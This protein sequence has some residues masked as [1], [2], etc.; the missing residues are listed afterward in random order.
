M[1][2]SVQALK[3]SPLFCDLPEKTIQEEILPHGM[4]L[5][6]P[7]GK[8]II[9]YLE[10]IDFFGIVISG[11]I[12]IMHIYA[13]GNFTIVDM[14]EKGD[15]IGLDLACT[16]SRISS[17]YAVSETPS[18]ILCFPASLISRSGQLSHDTYLIIISKLLSYLSS[19]NMRKEYRL[20]ILFQKGV[21]DRI[22][23][24]L[25]MQANKYQS[26]TF[27][28]PFSRNELASYLCIN[29]T[30][31]SHELSLLA[32]EGIIEFNRNTFTLKEWNPAAAN[33]QQSSSLY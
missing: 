20:A 17:Y 10:P 4:L 33:I 26:N 27:T 11:K 2:L 23:T 9:N 8:H 7:S 21:R 3:N 15:Y 14:L 16:R 31:L 25:T 5:S 28:L 1:D 32:Q 18:Q 19:E 12:S 6:F 13:N 29:R 24:F 30:N 22:M